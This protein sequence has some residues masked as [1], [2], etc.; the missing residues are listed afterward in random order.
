M[1]IKDI[2]LVIFDMD[3]TLLKSDTYAVVAVQ[4]A[5]ERYV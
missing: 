5:I 1:N 3:G 2:D 4:N